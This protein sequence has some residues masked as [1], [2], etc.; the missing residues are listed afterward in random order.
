[1]K[2]CVYM[3][4]LM[5][6]LN[7]NLVK[8]QVGQIQNGGFENWHNVQVYEYPDFGTHLIQWILLEYRLFGNQVMRVI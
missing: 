5:P 4:V 2:Y 3:F 1:M 8:A 7:I 6:L